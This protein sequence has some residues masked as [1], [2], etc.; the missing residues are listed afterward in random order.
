MI[1][2]VTADIRCTNTLDGGCVVKIDDKGEIDWLSPSALPVR[3]SYDVNVMVKPLGESY[4]RISGNPAKWLQGHNLFGT[5]DLQKLMYEFF[6]VLYEV[7][8]DDGLCPTISEMEDIENGRYT[9]SRVD[10][11]ESWALDS[12]SQVK[13]WIRAA[14]AKMHMP[15]RGKGVF[16]GDTLYWG[17]GSK[18]WFLKC[19]SKGDEIN[20]KRSKYPDEFRTQEMLDYAN[21][22]LRLEL[23]LCSKFLREMQL[24]WVYQWN[25]DTAKMLLLEY[26]SKLEMSN[27]FMLNDDILTLLPA[28]MKMAYL[29]WLHGEDLRVILPKNTFY[30]YRREFKRYDIDIALVR[31]KEQQDNKV[32]PMLQ[33]LEAKPMGIPDWAYEK[34]LVVCA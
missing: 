14:G 32:I 23:V 8:C 24:H 5:N 4:I 33:V 16:S 12:Q 17:K 30:R 7:L 3:G 21:R 15:H 25:K 28:R 19:Y 34:G 31:D 6:V 2:W 20:T 18:Y 27:N 10:I 26:V 22:S 1:D 9:V 29:S 11:N 13:A